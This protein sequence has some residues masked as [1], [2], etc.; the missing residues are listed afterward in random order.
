MKDKRDSG[1]ELLRFG[2][3]RHYKGENYLVLGVARDHCTNEEVVVYVRLYG[4]EGLPM[5]VQP[6]CR[7]LGYKKMR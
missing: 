4:R 7:F 6:L 3:Y 5:S 1:S 2:V